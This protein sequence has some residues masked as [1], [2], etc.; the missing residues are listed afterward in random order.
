[1]F[2]LIAI[3]INLSS[4]PSTEVGAFTY[5]QPFETL[6]TCNTFVAKNDADIKDTIKGIAAES[7]FRNVEIQINCVA[8]D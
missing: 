6:A 1:M 4:T 3:V 7:G 8:K 5:N 2:Y